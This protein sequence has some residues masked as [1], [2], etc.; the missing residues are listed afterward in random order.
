MLYLKFLVAYI[1]F[2]CFGFL[3]V[4]TFS[5]SLTLEHEIRETAETLYEEGSLIAKT[6]VNDLY[7]NQ[8][9]IENA[10]S[11]L[12]ALSTYLSA[13]I[14]IVNPSGTVVLN[15]LE[16]PDLSNPKVIEDFNPSI[17]A[18]SYYIRDDFFGE[19]DEE[20][21]SVYTPI[22][23]NYKIKGYVVIHQPMSE[24]RKRSDDYLSI[25]YITLAVLIFLSLIILLFFTEIFYIPL[26]KII[27]ATEQYAE[28]IC[29]KC[30]PRLPFPLNF[31]QRLSG[32]HA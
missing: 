18:D 15:S 31:H 28:K 20:M 11:Q 29:G 8:I 24:L 30:F 21:L 2:G 10:Y 5:S 22:T 13:S 9:T 23:S 17:T 32:G 4:A 16:M 27:R 7:N 3:A 1:I 25:T 12:K 14:W 19:F 6:Y 26:R